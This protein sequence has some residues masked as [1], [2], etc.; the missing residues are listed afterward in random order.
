M[1]ETWEDQNKGSNV[2]L[3]SLKVKEHHMSS[4]DSI[5]E[6][7]IFRHDTWPFLCQNLRL[8]AEIWSDTEIDTLETIKFY[9]VD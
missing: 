7:S 2:V 5:L 6:E 4:L 3:Y 1:R 9:W 8:F